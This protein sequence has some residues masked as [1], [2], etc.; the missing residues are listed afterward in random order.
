MYLSISEVKAHFSKYLK[1][2]QEGGTVIITSH[3][4]PIAQLIPLSTVHV[5]DFFKKELR[6]NFIWNGKTPKGGKSLP[7]IHGETA[8]DRILDCLLYTSDAADE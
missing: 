1:V 6:C 4:H 2:I 7:K 3:Q 5:K 8:S